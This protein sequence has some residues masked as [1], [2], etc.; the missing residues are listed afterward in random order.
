MSGI[1]R[2]QI[3]TDEALAAP[4]ILAKNLEELL[5]VLDKLIVKGKDLNNSFINQDSTAPVRE[6]IEKLSIEEVELNKI[7]KQIATQVA[8]NNETYVAQQKVLAGVKQQI[9]DKN[10]VSAQEAKLINQA[11]SSYAL[12]TQA[13]KV[14]RQQYALLTTEE[15]RNSKAGKE[16]LR[17][18]QEQADANEENNKSLGKSRGIIITQAE[19][20]QALDE[21]VD[22]AGTKVKNLGKQL[23]ALA[24]SPVF[25]VLAGLATIYA[26]LKAAAD[27][28][29][30]TSVEGQDA[31]KRREVISDAFF[32]TLKRGWA[33]S[34][35][36]VDE[37]TKGTESWYRFLTQAVTYLKNI[38]QIT[39]GDEIE[40]SGKKF[41][42]LSKK[43]LEY[44]KTI[45][46]AA[47]EHI[48]DTVDD[49]NTEIKVNEL[50]EKSKDK[51]HQTDEERLQALRDVGKL[52]S[53]QL[54][55]DL[56]L[57]ALDVQAARLEA[58]RNG[59]KLDA[60]KKLKDYTTD[61]LVAT[62]ATYEQLQAIAEAEAAESK[63]Q[64]D[65][66]AKRK[67]LLKQEIALIL[68]I[69]K[70]RRDA[71][72]REVDSSI[73]LR[74]SELQHQKLNAKQVSD[75]TAKSLD[76]RIVALTAGGAIESQLLKVQKQQELNIIKRAAEDRLREEAR[77]L[78]D[79]EQ[80]KTLSIDQQIALED[81]FTAQLLAKDV[82]YNNQKQA[83]TIKYN[84]LQLQNTKEQVE[85]IVKVTEEG[86]KKEHDLILKAAVE[87]TNLRK[88]EGDRKI[89]DIQQQAIDGSI[90]LEEAN[91]KIAKQQKENAISLTQGSIDALNN[92]LLLLIDNENK[93]LHV[94][95][96]TA[97][98][99]NKIEEDSAKE[100]ADIAEKLAALKIK[101]VGD[102]F[103]AQEK[104]TSTLVENLQLVQNIFSAYA[105]SVGDLFNSIT[106][107]RINDIQREENANE[108]SLQ[109]QL[110]AAGD[111]EAKKAQIQDQFDQK[112]RILERQKIT[113]QRRAAVFDKAVSAIQAGIATA[114]AVTKALPNIPLAVAVGIAGGIEVAAIL[115]KQIPQYYTG[116]VHKNTGDL[117]AGELGSELMIYPSGD[118]ELTKD[119]AT[120]YKNVPGGTEIIN[121]KKTMMM[122]AL[123]GINV[124]G[125]QAKAGEF[126]GA[127]LKRMNGYLESINNKLDNHDEH[128]WDDRG[129]RS[130]NKTAN[131]RIERL[132][133]KYS[134]RR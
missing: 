76:E 126:Y 60:K 111:S 57:A 48:L 83:I 102:I 86:L 7:Q 97:E 131:S 5:G 43:G 28:Y 12:L 90:T 107:N 114:L 25:L 120:L 74:E 88:I 63:L 23:L 20:F 119:R 53:D 62:K 121:H 35:K 17:I 14:N 124:G 24:A 94:K 55:G 95:G 56:K 84:D 118:M 54:D 96:L 87:A 92:E 73:Q 34:G 89:A 72:Q 36:Q 33:E 40:K 61:E 58:E 29:Y 105:K 50:L 91:K 66:A 64:S 110:K 106:E 79:D 44:Y 117:I 10:I 70:T 11:N 1:K 18:I 21:V 16:L 108:S 75:D 99:T 128:N 81:K 3:V 26:G 130:F 32:A 123:S 82:A 13:L 30:T 38:G 125:R 46:E 115:A 39:N 2:D 47:K 6:G 93:K 112:K 27:A 127:D 52:L 69:E 42:E 31:L 59:A 65:A 51:I 133:K 4:L 134:S 19:S 116:G 41:D 98:E 8:R 68:E 37:L 122:L 67:A 113:E 80:S 85:S 9:K 101:L 22:G 109:R 77:G 71:V 100:Q 49:A 104:E 132:G 15:Q 45:S 103:A 78:I 129:Y